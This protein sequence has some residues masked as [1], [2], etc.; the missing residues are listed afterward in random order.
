M[1][2]EGTG[3]MGANS[4]GRGVGAASFV[5]PQ[6]GGQSTGQQKDGLVLG[7]GQERAEKE[8]HK[9]GDWCFGH[10]RTLVSL[11]SWG[12]KQWGKAGGGCS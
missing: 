9:E 11:Q 1:S 7:S 6:R 5:H 4:R 3:D 2:G 8:E 12:W 10:R